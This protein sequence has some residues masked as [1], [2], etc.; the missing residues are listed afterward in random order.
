MRQLCQFTSLF[1]VVISL[2]STAQVTGVA[3]HFDALGAPYGGCGVPQDLLETQNFV[4]LNVFDTPGNYQMYTRPLTGANLQYL[5]EFNNG[6]NCGRWLKVTMGANCQGTNDGARNQPFCRGTGAKWV[7]DQYS[8]AV[9]YMLVADAC[10]DDNAWC[11][12]SPYHLDMATSSLNLFEKNGTTVKTMYPSAFN[13]REIEWE[14]V[15]AP[16]YEG[17]IAIYFI[18]GAEQYWPAIMVNHLPNGIHGIEQKI[19]NSW[20]KAEMNSDMGQSYILKSATFPLRIR[21][22][23]ANDQLLNNGREYFFNF[24]AACGS[25][26]SQ[27][28]TEVAYQTTEILTSIKDESELE[29]DYFFTVDDGTLIMNRKNSKVNGIISLLVNDLSGR[30]VLHKEGG[31]GEYQAYPLG[32][33][34]KGVYLVTLYS[35]N[36]SFQTSKIFY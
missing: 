35:Q 21:I 2:Q 22:V 27:P 31:I 1:L 15:E 24:P 17:D 3:T 16:D 34:S 5:G 32:A 11:R 10:G 8:G 29:N 6:L 25:K 20:V 4:A 36:G 26:C 13:N 19:G 23:D 33:I 28:A 12:D 18:K 7:D 14:Y 30:T 9:L